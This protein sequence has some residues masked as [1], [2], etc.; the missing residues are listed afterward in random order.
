M[1]KSFDGWKA[2]PSATDPKKQAILAR[3]TKDDGETI[4]FNV[5]A[6]RDKKAKPPESYNAGDKALIAKALQQGPSFFKYYK[7]WTNMGRGGKI[8]MTAHFV[9]ASGEAAPYNVSA[10][11]QLIANPPKKATAFDKAVLW[12]AAKDAPGMKTDLIEVLTGLRQRFAGASQDEARIQAGKDAASL[13]D[14][15]NP[16]D[17]INRYAK[18]LTKG[19]HKHLNEVKRCKAISE[20]L[21]HIKMHL[22]VALAHQRPDVI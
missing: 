16:L 9:K 12:A 1:F 11:E 22:T 15:Q 10:L 20:D 14:H 13:L 5:G 6:L 3:F 4:H 17:E 2:V 21:G 8:I 7:G 19:S 18:E